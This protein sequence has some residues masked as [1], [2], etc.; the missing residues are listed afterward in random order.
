LSDSRENRDQGNHELAEVAAVT[1]P[2]SDRLRLEQS[3]AYIASWLR[4]LSDDKRI[5]VSAS[6]QAQ[7]AVDYMRDLAPDDAQ[8]EPEGDTESGRSPA[9]A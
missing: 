2:C 5:V 9:S 1:R 4:A 6:Q 8:G 3:A 7:R